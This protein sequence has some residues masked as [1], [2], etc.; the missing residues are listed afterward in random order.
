[1]SLQIQESETGVTFA[2]KVVPG[3]SRSRIAGL[4]GTALK[5]NIAAAPEKG[6]AN[7]ELV[8]FLAKWLG[9]PKAAVHVIAGLHDPRKEVHI[10]GLKSEAVVRALEPFIL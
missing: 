1:M 8:L 6:K 3:S 2:V 4:L 10:D 5:V 9:I 7:K